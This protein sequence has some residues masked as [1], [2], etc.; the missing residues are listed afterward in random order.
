MPHSTVPVPGVTSAGL[1]K[2][3]C[4]ASA[5]CAVDPTLSFPHP[6]QHPHPHSQSTHSPRLSQRPVSSH[7]APASCLDRSGRK[8][9]QS[10]TMQ[11]TSGC[12]S[13]AA[14]S[15]AYLPSY[16]DATRRPDWLEL[17]ASH[18]PIGEYARL[19]LVSRRF[20]HQFAPRLWNDPLA[21]AG[22][23]GRDNG[24]SLPTRS[25]FYCRLCC[26]CCCSCSV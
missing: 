3:C 17:V 15:V 11:R 18:V 8:K 20:Y 10:S 22:M 21:A 24:Q 4:D 12:A 14:H 5:Q 16:Q 25:F 6:H 23:L 7:E 19:C 26:R 9:Q 2:V 13:P 1:V